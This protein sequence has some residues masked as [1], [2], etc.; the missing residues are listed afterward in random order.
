[1]ERDIVSGQNQVVELD[2][3]LRAWLAAAPKE[4]GS[5]NVSVDVD[6]MSFLGTLMLLSPQRR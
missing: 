4:R 1:L 6:P 5:V 3:S 2:D